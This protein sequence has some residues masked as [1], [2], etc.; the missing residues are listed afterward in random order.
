MDRVINKKT[1]QHI[2]DWIGT[3]LDS[4]SFYGQS[5]LDEII[6]H[7]QFDTAHA[8][9]EFGCGTGRFA[10]QLLG[11]YLPDDTRYTAID[12]SPKMIEITRSRLKPWQQRINIIKSAGN[13]KL[14]FSD[15]SFDRF[16]SSYVVDLLSH[17]DAIRLTDEAHRVLNEK[18]LICLVSITKGTTLFSKILMGSWRLIN[19]IH[20]VLTAGCRPVRLLPMLSAEK[21]A[22]TFHKVISQYGVSIEVVIAS[23]IKK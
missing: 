16:I 21:W 15:N 7:G 9:F 5:G 4:Q 2:Y 18:G 17:E 11:Q 14:D 1:I 22:V 23:A 20:P 8:V 10:Q 3:K 12:I 19:K 13:V 6:K